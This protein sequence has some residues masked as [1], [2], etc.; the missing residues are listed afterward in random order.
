MVSYR[1]LFKYL[2]YRGVVA[3]K[4]GGR[5]PSRK[6][7]GGLPPHF[8]SVGVEHMGFEYDGDSTETRWL[9][10]SDTDQDFPTEDFTIEE[11][12]ET[13]THAGKV[14]PILILKGVESGDTVQICAWKRDVLPCIKQYGGKP[15][16]WDAVGFEKKGK[17]YV[18]VPRAL[19]VRTERVE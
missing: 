11:A 7:G 9:I 6:D 19:K 12:K 14:M 3:E 1:D 17:R 13:T 2:L 8:F 5:R 16:Q 15:E 18:L 10:L 4:Q